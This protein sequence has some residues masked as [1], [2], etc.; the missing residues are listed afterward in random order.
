MRSGVEQGE[1]GIE[2]LQALTSLIFC[3]LAQHGLWL[4]NNHDGIGLG[5]HID[6]ATAAKLVTFVEDDTCRGIASTPLLVFLL[7]KGTVESLHVDDH[8][9]HAVAICKSI[10]LAQLL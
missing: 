9:L 4:V 8:H 7:V 1:E 6:G 5:Q 2:E 3:I 10:D